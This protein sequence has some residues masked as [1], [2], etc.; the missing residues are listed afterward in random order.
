[1]VVGSH[2]AG[3]RLRLGS[4]NVQ[5]SSGPGTTRSDLSLLPQDGGALSGHCG[6]VSG[7][8]VS[9][10]EDTGNGGKLHPTHSA[11]SC[12]Q[13][14]GSH[15]SGGLWRGYASTRLLAVVLTLAV[16]LFPSS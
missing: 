10:G 2:T 7:M 9:C 5:W 12:L 1:M 6:E 8:D 11:L 16:T 15:S 3:V 4:L 13:I 14:P